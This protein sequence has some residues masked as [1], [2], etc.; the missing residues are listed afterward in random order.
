MIA[1]RHHPITE[2]LA[3]FMALPG[4]QQHVTTAQF[5]DGSADRFAPVANFDGA[6]HRG[7]DGGADGRGILGTR[8]VIGHDHPIGLGRSDGAHHR[9]LA[10]IAIAACP[11]DN[12]EPGRD[13]RPQRIERFGERVRLV[14]IVDEYPRAATRAHELDP[15]FGASQMFECRKHQSRIAAGGNGEPGGDKRI[16]DL[17]GTDQRQLDLKFSAA[18]LNRQNLSETLSETFGKPN[19]AA[20]GTADAEDGKLPRLGEFYYFLRV[21]VVDVDNCGAARRNQFAK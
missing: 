10:A 11:E 15:P 2:N 18:I 7:Q 19:N 9:A 21:L 13:H 4:Y 16:F 8:I 6:G 12:N 17:E 5:G 14:R 20:F 3:G 1:E